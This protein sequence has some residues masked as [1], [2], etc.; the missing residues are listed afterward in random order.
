MKLIEYLCVKSILHVIKPEKVRI[1]GDVKPPSS[2]DYWKELSAN[3]SIEWVQIDRP[4]SRY[5]QNFS[6]SPIQHLSD[7]ARLE[8][9]YNEGGIYSDFDIIWV[10][11]LDTFRHMDVDLVASNDITSYCNEFPNSI[12]IG[13]FLAPPRSPFVAAWLAGYRKYDL[14]P[15]DYVA[16]S[17]CEPYKV[18]EKNPRRVYI[19]NRLQMIYFNGWSAFIPRYTTVSQEELKEFNNKLDWKNDGAYGY[20]LPRHGDLYSTKN[21]NNSNKDTLPIK[22]ATYILNL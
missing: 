16:I 5:G 19:D 21:Y 10:K 1:H 12:Q 6:D 4:V 8:V 13:T 22:I 20:H 9:V 2:D 3:P 15:G 17:M 14:F 18:Y 7:I 11:P